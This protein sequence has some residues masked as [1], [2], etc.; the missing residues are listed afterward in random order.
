MRAVERKNKRAEIEQAMK[1][2]P[3]KVEKDY[4]A[5]KQEV[6]A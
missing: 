2:K 1:G 3:K 5:S 6:A 4:I